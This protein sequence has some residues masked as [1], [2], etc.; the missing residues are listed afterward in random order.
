M[1]DLKAWINNAI[2]DT[3]RSATIDKESV[4]GSLRERCKEMKN[5][6]KYLKELDSFLQTKFKSPQ[7]TSLQTSH[8]ES[9]SSTLLLLKRLVALPPT[10]VCRERRQV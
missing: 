8:S 7:A 1:R 2:Q 9:M 10:Q 6:W 3:Q 4:N 5:L